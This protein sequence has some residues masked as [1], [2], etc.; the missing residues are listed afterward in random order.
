MMGTTRPVTITSRSESALSKFIRG[1][2]LSAIT[3]VP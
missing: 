2:G 1:H 3:E